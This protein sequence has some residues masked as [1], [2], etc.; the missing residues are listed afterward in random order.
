VFGRGSAPEAGRI[1]ALLRRETVGGALLLAIFF[2]VAGAA[3]DH[4]M[5][6]VLVGSALS[7]ALAAVVLGRRN[8]ARSAEPVLPQHLPGRR[9]RHGRDPRPLAECMP[10]GGRMLR[11]P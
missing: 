1:A 2:F 11:C 8:R 9:E 5:V 6:G 4:V 3:D 7:A 10:A